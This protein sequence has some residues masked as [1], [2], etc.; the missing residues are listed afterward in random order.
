MSSSEDETSSSSESSIH[1]INDSVLTSST[2]E[3]DEKEWVDGGGNGGVGG[4]DDSESSTEEETA[5][6]EVDS[7]DEEEDVGK[8]DP[9]IYNKEVGKPRSLSHDKAKVLKTATA[10]QQKR[11]GTP[12]QIPTNHPTQKKNKKANRQSTPSA[13]APRTSHDGPAPSDEDEEKGGTKR[14]GRPSPF[15]DEQREYIDVNYG[16]E[17]GRLINKYSRKKHSHKLTAWKSKKVSEIMGS[18]LFAG[19]LDDSKTKAQW[20]Q[21]G[22]RACLSRIELTN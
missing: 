22:M 14:K 8:N 7:S 5:S 21:V 12:I 9:M 15:T 17:W 10:T 11:K 1:P 13:K 16:A 4:T 20:R 2:E 6:S 19:K 18:P 3:T